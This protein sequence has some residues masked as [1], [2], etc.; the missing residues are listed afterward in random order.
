MI[1]EGA[2]QI[3]PRITL[4]PALQAW[5]IYLNDK[6]SSPHTITAFLGDL[7]L[8]AS[9]L[10]PDR[11]VGEISLADLNNFLRWME[12]E[13]DVPCS[14]K[15]LARRI[16]SLKS[17]FRWLHEGGVIPA[18][19]AEQ[20]VQKSVR[21]PLPEILSPEEVENIL[22]TAL[23]YRQKPDPDLRSYLLFTLILETGIKKGEC[24]SLS[25]NHIQLDAPDDPLIFIRY[26]SPQNRYKE[27]K[28]NLSQDWIAAYQEY[29]LHHNLDDRLFPWSARMLEYILED[30]GKDA[31][32]KKRVSFS[33]CR[34][35]SA[36]QDWQSGMEPNK[37]RQKLGISEV[38]WREI[39][40]KLQIL[41]KDVSSEEDSEET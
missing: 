31:G 27:R 37:I 32:I 7:R 18:N 12:H 30:L 19:P 3:N 35:T 16:T 17:F 24:L 13:R 4:A 11:Q 38:Q 10:P 34:W 40:R 29:R 2:F 26:A 41:S 6:G 9:Y 33:M 36:V 23:A 14:P 22:D 21:S 28:L 5:E 1:N 39:S 15:T 20:V 8:L 25:P